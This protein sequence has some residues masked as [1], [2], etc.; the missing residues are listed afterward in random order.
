MRKALLMASVLLAMTSTLAFAEGVDLAWNACINQAGASDLKT[1][2]CLVNT[3]GQAMYV[4]FNPPAGI[5]KLEGIEVFVD[6]QVAGGALT[7]WWDYSLGQTRNA[8]LVT[9]HPTPADANG[10]PL[11][12][13]GNHYFLENASSGGGGMVVTGADRGQLK[14]IGAISAGSGLP[15]AADAQQFGMGFRFTNTGTTT[16]LGCL[17]AA[18]FVVNTVNLTSLNLP[19]VVLTSP[20]VRNYVTWQGNAAGTNCP[21]ATPARNSTWGSLKALYR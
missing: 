2:T 16:C 19:N 15:V 3:G 12:A 8:A 4:S 9:Q 5:Q 14:G 21:G 13:C 1:S 10:A 18:C 17:Q 7:C 20:N 6:Y 11:I